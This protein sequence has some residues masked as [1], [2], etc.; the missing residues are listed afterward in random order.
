LIQIEE[1]KIKKSVGIK[2][3]HLKARN[4]N[5][6]EHWISGYSYRELG[7]MYNLSATQIQTIIRQLFRKL[8][9]RLWKSKNP[10]RAIKMF[11]DQKPFF[12]TI[13]MADFVAKSKGN[14]KISPDN[15]KSPRD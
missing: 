8:W 6:F 10:H 13:N 5:I 12:L 3:Y 14:I 11:L 7:K 15:L 9:Y 4:Y 1:D 2:K